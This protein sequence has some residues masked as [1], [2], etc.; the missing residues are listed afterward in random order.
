MSGF[1]AE[2]RVRRV[3]PVTHDVTSVV[4]DPPP[5]WDGRFDAGQHLVLAARPDGPAGPVVERCYTISSPPTRSATLTITVKRQ[6]GGV[7]SPWLHDHVRPGDLLRFRGPVG[8]FTHVAHPAPAYLFLTAGSG[9]TP[10]MSMVRALADSGS[11]ADVVFVHSARTPA[12]IVFRRE[13]AAL[14]ETGLAVRV[15]SVC[16]ADAPGERWQGP[17]GRLSEPLLR[18]V[19]PDVRER[20][21]FLCGPPAY[22]TGA[23]TLLDGLGVD[24]E[25]VHRESFSVGAATPVFEDAGAAALARIELKRS[26]RVVT[27]APGATVLDAVTTAGV[28]LRSS[29]RQG[30]CGTCKLR[31]VEGQVEMRHQ[32]GIRHREVDAGHF[33][34]CCSRPTTDLVLDA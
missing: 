10:A 8:A 33:L 19:A 34:P 11:D 21:V 7:V 20:E 32:G 15:T 29:C 6:P 9:I 2:V 25:R 24:P 26:G 1:D 23:V 3:V 22:M 5:G 16:E 31:L 14:P 4:L 17:V 12:D 28:M 30:L 18:L 27:C 13:L